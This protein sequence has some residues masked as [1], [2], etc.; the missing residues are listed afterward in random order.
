MSTMKIHIIPL[1]EL[2]KMHTKALMSRRKALLTCE[3]SFA[4]SDRIGHE[5]PEPSD[6]LGYIEFKDTAEWQQAMQDVKAVLSNREHIPN[7]QESRA[8]RQ[9]KAKKTP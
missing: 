8:Q 7:K 1:T 5:K 4:L 9:A 6:K 2:E 3:A